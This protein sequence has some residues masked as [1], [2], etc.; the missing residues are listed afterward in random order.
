[1]NIRILNAVALLL[2]SHQVS[3]DTELKMAVE[4]DYQYLESLYHYL[5]RNPELSFHEKKTAARISKELKQ[6]GF[7]V[8]EK[9]GGHGVVGVIKNGAGPT[10]MLRTDLDAL[11]VE[12]KTGLDYASKTQVTDDLGNTV[13]TMHAC[14]HDIHMAVFAGTA[15][16]LASMK[17]KWKGTL[18]MIGEPAE[19]RG[20]GARA[21]L[22]DGLYTRFPR[23]DYA[24]GLHANAVLPAGQI[25]YVE[26]YALANV[27]MVDIHLPGIGGHGAYPHTTKDPIVLAAQI[28][29]ALQTLVSRE[30]SPLDPAVVTV[31]SIHGGTKHNIIPDQV[32]M[33]LT[34]RSYTDENREA[35][36]T[37]I[38]RIAKAQAQV[39]GF[40]AEKMPVIKVRDEFTPALYNNPELTAR[41][42]GV[43]KER[44]GAERIV[45]VQPVMGGEDFSEYG[46]VEPK[47][48]SFFF[49]L[50]AVNPQAIEIAEKKGESLPSLHSAYFA[51]LAKPTIQM[52]VEA[53]TA[54][55][56][57]LFN[58]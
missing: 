45:K 17:D 48:P 19:E 3:A 9:V 16:R 44:F 11:P 10:V 15:R 33:Q 31:G 38:K 40:P 22:A 21:M 34:V 57:D 6:V 7:D 29:N 27:D 12:E 14:G 32:H 24:M 56:L 30:L 2:L 55:A 36:L 42:A 49:W 4:R 18:V 37:G 35:L 58:K 39:M 50:G 41:V 23:P 1:M 46:R 5:H 8:T 13:N 28:I 20:A 43:F 47:V 54:A 26:G 52:G 25:G 53:M 51:P